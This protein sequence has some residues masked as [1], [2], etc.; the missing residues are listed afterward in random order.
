MSSISVCLPLKGNKIEVCQS[1]T[2]DEVKVFFQANHM[3]NKELTSNEK[4]ED[5]DK[6]AKLK[7]FLDH[8][9]KQCHYFY[10]AA[11]HLT[12]LCKPFKNST[13]YPIQCLMSTMNAITKFSR[14][15]WES[16]LRRTSPTKT[17]AKKNSLGIPFNP[18]KQ[19]AM[20]SN[21]IIE[22]TKCNKL[23][24]IYVQKK[25]S[26]MCVRAFK[27]VLCV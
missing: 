27:K 3:L 1:I 20:N 2:D 15:F 9:T 26:V 25:I 18:S 7:W 6:C 12:Y 23:H 4:N 24:I 14:C 8:S 17:L 16:D 19:H 22:S 11:Y 10:S 5:L 21:L 13:I